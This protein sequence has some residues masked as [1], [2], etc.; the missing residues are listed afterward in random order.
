MGINVDEN[1]DQTMLEYVIEQVQESGSSMSDSMTEARNLLHKFEF[2]TSRWNQRVSFL[3]GG[4][5][6]R[7]QLLSVLSRNPNFLVLDEP[8][9]DLD[10][11]TLQSLETYLTTE[12]QGVLLVVSHDRFFADKVADHI[13]IFEGNGVIKDFTGTL[14]EY[15]SALVELEAPGGDFS[16]NG[17]SKR[18]S[19][20]YYKDEKATRN[21]RRNDLQRAKKNMDNLENAVERLKVEAQSVQDEIDSTGSD[22]GWSVLADLTEKL[23]NINEQID[24]KEVEWMEFAEMVEATELD[25]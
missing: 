4:E 14:T 3:S 10:L 12:F 19:K 25:A 21:R 8:S 5:K 20:A 22:K 11:P 16:A 9:V 24:K 15:A 7:L 18:K 6:R 13:F 23:D 2:P 1:L 17:D